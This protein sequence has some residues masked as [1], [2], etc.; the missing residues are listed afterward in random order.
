MQLVSG[1]APSVGG[2]HFLH[3]VATA[4][5]SPI[6]IAWLR[7]G[8]MVR[9]TRLTRRLVRHWP[10]ASQ[11][12]SNVEHHWPD[13]GQHS[14]IVGQDSSDAGQQRYTPSTK[15]AI[16]ITSESVASSVRP[17]RNADDAIDF[18]SEMTNSETVDS[19]MNQ[20]LDI[21]YN[22]KISKLLD[23]L[24]ATDGLADRTSN[25][26]IV[27][28]SQHASTRDNFHFG[29]LTQVGRSVRSKGNND[30]GDVHFGVMVS[31]KEPMLSTEA[32]AT[33]L[34]G[35]PTNLRSLP[36][37]LR[38]QPTTEL[39]F[40]VMHATPGTDN[41]DRL[42]AIR[43]LHL[44]AREQ[45]FPH[46][47]P[48]Q[49]LNGDPEDF[50]NYP[51][52]NGSNEDRGH[53][54]SYPDYDGSPLGHEQFLDYPDYDGSNY[55][56]EHSYDESDYIRE[57]DVFG[58]Y[59]D[60]R[61]DRTEARHF[62]DAVQYNET[63]RDRQLGSDD[64]HSPASEFLPLETL[65]ISTA[66]QA[67]EITNHNIEET[68]GFYINGSPNYQFRYLNNVS[69]QLKS[70]ETLYEDSHQFISTG[71][72]TLLDNNHAIPS[73]H[74]HPHQLGN[75]IGP[76]R[77]N[78]G[79]PNVTLFDD[80]H[81]APLRLDDHQWP[82]PSTEAAEN[83]WTSAASFALAPRLASSV[84]GGD[85]LPEYFAG[86]EVAEDD[87]LLNIN[88]LGDRSSALQFLSV[89]PRHSGRY[90]C[91]AVNA[92]GSD[93]QDQFIAVNGALIARA[94]CM[95]AKELN[96]SS[97]SLNCYQCSVSSWSQIFISLKD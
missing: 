17:K 42:A 45:H 67:T 62:P 16:V 93:R 22:E 56:D 66:Q 40:G 70:N 76:S 83:M 68:E 26:S 32:P 8:K 1:A 20:Q 39:V 54:L 55:G 41:V 81:T 27:A 14:P 44:S 11:H 10:D 12:W 64:H 9:H 18:T 78:H 94:Q 84:T 96:S 87:P 95:K 91:L 29:V 63:I 61:W 6:A 82:S 21:L 35:Q 5:D 53:F 24:H 46:G 92:A 77:G 31:H 90:T 19:I 48:Q 89:Q 49:T 33:I 15:S 52:Y 65:V 73:F 58:K 25:V 50:S 4:G 88:R 85:D 71:N 72:V 59:S 34:L 51:D 69:S 75:K 80:D 79:L 60:E 7:D 86:L 13:A 23:K 28:S 74:L 38:G 57:P 30:G 3:C 37:D 36:I 2:G 97:V 43:G 47:E